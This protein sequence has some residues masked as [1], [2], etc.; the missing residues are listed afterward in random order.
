M[1]FVFKALD[2][3]VSSNIYVSFG[4]LVLTWVSLDIR[5]LR[6][7]DLLGFV[8]F[9]TLFIYNFIRLVRVHP[10]VMEGDSNRHKIIFRYRELLWAL[11]IVSGFI[12]CYFFTSLYR[13]IWVYLLPMSIVSVTYVLPVYK[14]SFGH[15]VRL[16]DVP[17]LKIFLIAMTWAFV[18]EGLPSILSIDKVDSL[19]LLERFLF[20]FAITIPFDIRD[21]HFDKMSLRTLPQLFGPVGARRIGIS[22]LLVAELILAYR[23]FFENSIDFWSGIVVYF[24]YEVSAFL[25]YK[26]H[27]NS[28]ERYVT[29][30]VEGMCIFMGV[31]YLLQKQL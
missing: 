3:L 20:V 15:W 10:M 25:V 26:S 24:T 17:C 18:T 29:L 14:T 1:K 6:C 13:S 8:F 5:Q 30:G 22:A 28:K 4:V 19:A 16:R 12:A 2:L 7:D 21:L 31:M 9:S 11:S 27:P 23:C